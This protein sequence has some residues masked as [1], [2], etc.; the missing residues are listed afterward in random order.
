MGA[1]LALAGSGEYLP[2]M[3]RVDRYL[4]GLLDRPADVVCL[5]TAAGTEG[6]ARLRYWMD[7]GVAHFTRLGVPV[8][9]LPVSDRAGAENLAYAERTRRASVVYLSGGHPGYLHRTLVDTPLWQAILS[10]HQGGGVVAG[11]SAG[12]MIMGDRIPGFRG[13]FAWQPGFGLLPG[14]V[15]VPHYDE[16]PEALLGPARTIALR[17]HTLLGIEGNT[18]LVVRSTGWEAHGQGGV[19]VW[20]NTRKQRY[21]DGQ[22]IP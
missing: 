12:A 15:I 16:I 18:A 20:D 2:P 19:T 1:M 9:A 6:E 3:E 10:V 17:R 7:L 11:C 4:L 8:E 13:R 21:T 14:Y 5:P 22:T